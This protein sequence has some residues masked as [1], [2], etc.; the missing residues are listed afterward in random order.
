MKKKIKT[1][2]VR[3]LMEWICNIPVGK[4]N[5]RIEFT[6][7]V[8]TSYGN[9]PAK[10]VTKD[11]LQ[12]TIIENS[13]LF[14]NKRIELLSVI[15]TDEDEDRIAS[16]PAN[17]AEKPAESSKTE[18]VVE[19]KEKAEHGGDEV[20]A[21]ANNVPTTVKEFTCN[22]DAKDFM[23]SEFGVKRSSMRT[24]ADIIKTGSTLGID[25]RFVE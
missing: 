19:K 21:D 18:A 2:G 13:D 11:L 20:E 24:R 8:L 17:E 1:Y 16:A 23:E 12:Q 14:K 15:D 3:G 25:V 10:F 4:S 7:G 22:D 9:T 5:M 6:G